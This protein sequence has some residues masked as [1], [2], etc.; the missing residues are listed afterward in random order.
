[1]SDHEGPAGP[2]EVSTGVDPQLQLQAIPLEHIHHA[3]QLQA[4]IRENRIG[5][6]FDQTRR[7]ERLPHTVKR[8][9]ADFGE[10]F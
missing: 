10:G 8:M 5:L 4:D 1:V 6:S 9:H 2:L 3:A 7:K